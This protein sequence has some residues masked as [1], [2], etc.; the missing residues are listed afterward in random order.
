[1]KKIIFTFFLS[2]LFFSCAQKQFNPKLIKTLEPFRTPESVLVAPNGI[3]YVSNIGGFGVDGDGAISKIQND[4]VTILVNG[5]NDPK[6][7]AYKEGNIYAADKNQIWKV[8]IKSRSKSIFVDSTAFPTVPKFL[9]DLVFDKNGNL[10]VSET[11]SFDST[12]GAIYKISPDG[13]VSTFINYK[14]SPEIHSP[15]GLLFDK[16]NNLLDI[17]LST[18]RLLK[19]S[20]D[21]KNVKVI[22]RSAKMGDG[23]AYDS[24][25]F[26]Y[27][28]D[29]TGGRIFRMNNDDKAVVIDSGFKAPADITID[30]TKDYLLV[31]EFNANRVDI[32]RLY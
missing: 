8:D 21:G 7:L 13:N 1:M 23:I 32:V 31:P 28:S 30:M 27:F 19:I 11:G 26:L 12:D 17:D 20:P 6:G 18:G 4:S 16:E 22:N 15:N 5:M 9:N 3:Y 10:F 14:V 24:R 2:I 25:G 29:W